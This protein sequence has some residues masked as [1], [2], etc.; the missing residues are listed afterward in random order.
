MNAIRQARLKKGLS[1]QELAAAAE[2]SQGYLSDLENGKAFA[3]REFAKVLANILNINV[4]DVLYP[5]GSGKEQ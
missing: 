3:S 4:V 5:E 2:C 1:Q